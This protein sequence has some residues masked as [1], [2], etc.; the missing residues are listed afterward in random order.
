MPCFFINYVQGFG[1]IF[2]LK[3]GT[4]ILPKMQKT[5]LEYAR[6]EVNRNVQAYF[7]QGT[8]L[9]DLLF[10]GLNEHYSE[11]VSALARLLAWSDYAEFR[12]NV[13]QRKPAEVSPAEREEIMALNADDMAL[14][15][16]ACALREARE[17]RGE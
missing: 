11:D 10:V 12:H 7:L 4:N 16:E 2:Y 9:S 17:K 15:E 5:L 14:Y 6:T 1:S 13:T 8:R 3:H